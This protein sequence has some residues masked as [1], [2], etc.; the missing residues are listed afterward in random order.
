MNPR[1]YPAIGLLSAATIAFQLALMQILAILV[2][3]LPL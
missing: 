1:A 3:P 2:A